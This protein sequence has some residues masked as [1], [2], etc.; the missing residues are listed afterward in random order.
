LLAILGVAAMLT[1]RE[2]R[3]AS[4]QSITSWRLEL[5]AGGLLLLLSIFINT[6]GAAAHAT[7]LW[8]LR[9]K[10]IDSH[11]ERLWDWRQPQFLADYLPYPEP[12]EFPPVSNAR[13]ECGKP[14]A[15]EFF[16]YGW[17]QDENGNCWTDS[18][19]AIV[20][21]SS[22]S[23]NVVLRIHMAPFLATGKITAQRWKLALNDR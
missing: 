5:V 18:S 2:S 10:E 7:W 17:L 19:A 11:P 4:A 8:N 16:L 22:R 14:E 9:P 21:A 12:R 13:I 6:L 3:S 20:F 1:R 23:K 15:E